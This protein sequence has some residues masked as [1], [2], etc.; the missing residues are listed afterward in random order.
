M[1]RIGSQNASNCRCVKHVFLASLCLIFGCVSSVAA[2]KLVPQRIEL[3]N[4]AKFSLHLPANYEITPVAQGLSRPRFFAIAPDNRLFL[5][6]LHDKSDNNLGAVLIL[7][8]FDLKTRRFEIVTRYLTGLRNPNS[9]AFWT[10][11]ETDQTYIYIALTDKLVRYEYVEGDNKP[12]GKPQTIATF[13]AS[14]LSYKYGGW[15]LTRT[16]AIGPNDKIYVS[17]GSSGDALIEK[18]AVRAAVLEM[19]P[20]GTGFKI[21]ARGLRNAVGLKWVGKQLYATNQGG[22]ALGDNRPAE[23]FYRLQ[24][25]L[26]AGWPF[27][28]Y[29]DGQIRPDTR[30]S[31]PDGIAHVAK[32]VAAFPAHSSALG[33][34][35]FDDKTPDVNLKNRFLVA[36]HGSGFKRLERG[37]SVNSFQPGRA[38]EPFLSGWLQRGR[39]VGRP[40]DVMAWQ[41]GFLVSDDFAGVVYW[42]RERKTP[43][44]ARFSPVK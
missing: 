16:L 37:Y 22:D 4:G 11:L 38:S 3:Q 20:D 43:L 31:R 33:F 35:F 5:T 10:D 42:V 17:V 18:E 25:G 7:D 28:Y 15:H 19:N 39:I 36:L 32:P 34:C 9:V 23:T 41:D 40:C 44:Q 24:D 21:Y 2:P 1:R 27:A 14:G 30:F 6:E 12:S 8:G 26:D 13:P 29:C